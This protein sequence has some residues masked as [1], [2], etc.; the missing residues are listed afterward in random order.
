M[1]LRDVAYAGGWKEPTTVLKI[2]QQPDAETLERVVQQ[3]RKL[4]EA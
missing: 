4:R 3:P 1:E 2:Y